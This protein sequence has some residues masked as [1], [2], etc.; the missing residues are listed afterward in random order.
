V[1]GANDCA[2]FAA[3]AIEAM[4]GVDIA[5]DFRGKYHDEASALALI[6]S[7]TGGSTVADAAAYCAAQ[8]GLVEWTQPDPGTPGSRLPAPLLAR[9][10]DLVVLPDAGRIIA[11]VVHL[12]GR[13]VAVV[14]E[15]GLKRIPAAAAAPG[16][17]SV[18]SHDKLYRVLSGDAL[19]VVGRVHRSTAVDRCVARS[20]SRT[21]VLQ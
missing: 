1:W 9:R 14:G 11:G 15:A 2:L 20:R 17:S 7:I 5:A 16:R 19:Q 8:H 18:K 12:N 13:D 3:D 4:T 21:K 10:G 6:H